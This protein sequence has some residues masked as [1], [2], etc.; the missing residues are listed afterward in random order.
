MK[1]VPFHNAVVC[2]AVYPRSTSK[3]LTAM[4]SMAGGTEHR[5]MKVIAV[6]PGKR[7]ENQE[8][9]A[10]AKGDESKMPRYPMNVREGDVVLVADAIEFK[11]GGP[12]TKSFYLTNDTHILGRVDGLEFSEDQK[13]AMEAGL[14]NEDGKE[15]DRG[16]SFI[17]KGS[18]R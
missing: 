3:I 10:A 6:G 7:V 2:L 11:P 13:E 1:I 16:G 8:A 9:A 14:A 12:G 15:G 4:P 17:N 18:A 5:V